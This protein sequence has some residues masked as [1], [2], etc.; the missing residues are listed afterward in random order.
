MDQANAGYLTHEDRIVGAL[1]FASGSADG[2]AFLAFHEIFTSAMTGNTALLGLALGQGH[3]AAGIRSIAALAGFSLGCICGTLLDSMRPTTPKQ[4]RLRLLIGAE[5]VGLAAVALL[6]AVLPHP[7]YH[8]PLYLMIVIAAWAM[9]VQS[10]AARTIDLPG[11]STVVFTTTLSIIVM[12]LTRNAIAFKTHEKMKPITLRQVIALTIYLAGG[13]LSGFLA[14]YLPDAI[15]VPA[16]IAAIVALIAARSFK[17]E[18]DKKEN[19]AS[20]AT[21]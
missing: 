15:A 18:A 14:M 10:I 6:W 8:A 5:I 4:I 2:M 16:L 20:N 9:G 7:V 19:A 21:V 1:A 13:A 12:T 17:P 3:L 11:L